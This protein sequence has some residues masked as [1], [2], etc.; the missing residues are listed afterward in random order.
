[1]TTNLAQ[2]TAEILI[3]GAGYW[4]VCNVCGVGGSRQCQ[5]HSANQGKDR[6]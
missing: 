2:A 1:M 4:Y 5:S 6:N 3:A